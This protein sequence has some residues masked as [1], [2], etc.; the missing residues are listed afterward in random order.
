MDKRQIASGTGRPRSQAANRAI[1]DAAQELL[2]SEGYDGLRLEHVAAKAGVGKATLYRRWSS[3]AELAE[4]LLEELAIP[5]ITLPDTDDTRAALLE[6][7]MNTITALTETSFGPVIRALLSQI[8]I[9]PK[10]GD[11]FRATVKEARRSQVAAVI[12]RGIERG[13]LHP[14]SHA[15]TVA[16]IL[17]GPIYY[18]LI[19]GGPLDEQF[20][21][22]IVATFLEGHSDPA[23]GQNR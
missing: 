4:A 3:K 15:S 16:E 21:E 19:F 23:A 9:N 12:D 5:A 7:V 18:R 13:D 17:V 22:D 6:V 14:T 8:A 1:L 10:L 2:I 11:P 20:A